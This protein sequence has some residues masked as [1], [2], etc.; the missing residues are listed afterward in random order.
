L[1][2]PIQPLVSLNSTNIF[3]LWTLTTD[4][5]FGGKTTCNISMT[6]KSSNL[7]FIKIALFNGNLVLLSNSK[8]TLP[9]FARMWLIVSL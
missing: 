1:E 8:I 6:D 2:P 7:L 9:S 4:K 5:I 3:K